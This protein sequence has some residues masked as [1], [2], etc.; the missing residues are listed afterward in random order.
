MKKIL[1]FIGLL[2]NLF[3]MGQAAYVQDYVFAT[4]FLAAFVGSII[5][6]IDSNDD[7]PPKPNSLKQ[8]DETGGSA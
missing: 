2:I 6:F 1:I 7:E 3:G 5:L 4:A 8:T